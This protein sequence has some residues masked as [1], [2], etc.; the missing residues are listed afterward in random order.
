MF[1]YQITPPSGIT[2]GSSN[3]TSSNIQFAEWFDPKYLNWSEL[4]KNPSDGAIQLLISNPD[5]IV[6][7]HLVLNT[8]ENAIELLKENDFIERYY[9]YCH[10]WISSNE[11]DACLQLLLENPKYINWSALSGNSNSQ[12]VLMLKQNYD[13]IDWDRLASNKNP[14]AI[15]MLISKERDIT[16][17]SILGNPSDLAMNIIEKIPLGEINYTFLCANESERALNILEKVSIHRINLYVLALN[18][19]D[20]AIRLVASILPQEREI[21]DNIKYFCVMQQLCRNRNPNAVTLAFER[22]DRIQVLKNISSNPNIFAITPYIL[23]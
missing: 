20:R 18:A 1:D 21:C 17:R 16:R 22:F 7:R 5:K 4:S 11:S 23:K 9:E 6:W 10:F 14:E 2:L 13:K 3:L 8:N 19:N 15:R 12:A